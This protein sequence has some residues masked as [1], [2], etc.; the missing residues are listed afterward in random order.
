MRRTLNAC[1]SGLTVAA[2]VVLLTAC[3]GSDD[4]SA[5]SSSS[6]PEETSSAPA[7]DSEF[8]SDAADIQ[9]QVGASFNTEDPAA[10]VQELR[11]AAASVQSIDAPDEI[12]EDWSALAAGVDSI[13]TALESTDLN[14]PAAQESL[15]AQLEQ[16][17]TD[18]GSASANVEDYL[19]NECG[20]EPDTAE[21]AAPTS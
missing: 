9:E 18:L 10:L 13:A 15:G 17:Q 7:E 14:D 12:A 4:D 2:A 16:L 6:A 11:D 8:C 19:V 5:A 20:L 21:T 3:G 1:R